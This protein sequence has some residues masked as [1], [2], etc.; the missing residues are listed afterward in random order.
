MSIRTGITDAGSEITD[1]VNKTVGQYAYGF[2]NPREPAVMH[3]AS[4]LAWE[5]PHATPRHGPY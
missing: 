2:H 5:E 3:P 4:P 1:R